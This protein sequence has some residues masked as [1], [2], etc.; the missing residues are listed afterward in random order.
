MVT[1]LYLEDKRTELPEALT[2]SLLEMA[3]ITRENA[4]NLARAKLP[5]RD[6]DLDLAKLLQRR[7]FVVYFTH[8]LALEVA[9]VM[10]EHDQYIQSAYVFEES[11]N[12]DA[13]TEDYL[14]TMDLTI[15]LLLLVTSAS[16]ALESFITSFDRA[17]TEALRELPSAE[18]ARRVSFLD[19]IPVT[20]KDVE[21]G[22]GYAVLLRSVF[23]PPLKI[24]QRD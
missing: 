12:P 8:A 4:I 3:E 19:V 5:R 6:Q 10:A 13:E 2:L 20:E 11:T 14:A 21:D 23:A 9:W 15:H 17:L 7:D 1:E 16:A 24:W 18:Y 22:R